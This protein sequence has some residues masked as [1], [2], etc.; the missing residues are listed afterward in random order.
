M[1]VG[2]GP[3][4]WLWR[5]TSAMRASYFAA[6]AATGCLSRRAMT[7]FLDDVLGGVGPGIDS[8]SAHE[9]VRDAVTSCDLFHTRSVSAGLHHRCVRACTTSS[10]SSALPW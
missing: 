6:I 5:H 10:D 8:A 7:H 4:G 3:Q 1:R 2:N 9:L